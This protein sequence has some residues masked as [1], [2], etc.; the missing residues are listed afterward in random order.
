V[1]GTVS[2]NNGQSFTFRQEDAFGRAVKNFHLSPR[3]R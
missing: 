2:C 3:I 1:G